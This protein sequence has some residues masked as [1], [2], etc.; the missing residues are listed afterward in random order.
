[1]NRTTRSAIA[2]LSLS[3]AALVGI[4]LKEGYTDEAIIPVPGD[5]PTIGFGTTG[6]VR[7]GD[8][9][10]PPKA[11]ERAFQDIEHYEGALKQCVKVPLYQSEYDAYVGLAYNIGP[12]AFCH[13]T[14]VK[15][16]NAKDY[17][18]ACEAILMWKK[19]RGFD[20][21]TPGNRVCSGLWKRRLEEHAKCVEGQ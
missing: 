15:R 6:G 3:A 10:T 4:V 13:S 17:A 20:C 2:A 19:F 5:V 7:L 14:V 9:T 16:L 12:T 11:L 21:S 8:K 18:G 1:M